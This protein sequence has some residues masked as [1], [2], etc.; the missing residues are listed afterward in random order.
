[1]TR[2]LKLAWAVTGIVSVAV[3][4]LWSYSYLAGEELAWVGERRLLQANASHGS[5]R[6]LYVRLEEGV[7]PFSGPRFQH[8]RERAAPVT[9]RFSGGDFRTHWV[10]GPV[11][12]IVGREQLMFKPWLR[13]VELILPYWLVLLLTLVP[14]PWLRRR[15]RRA[16]RASEGRCLRCGYDLRASPQRCPECG[17]VA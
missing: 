8:L 4:A 1:M 10:V 3:L 13:F 7:V 9:P 11:S 2:R 12:F 6:F 17:A 14:F 5:V 16:H 15:T